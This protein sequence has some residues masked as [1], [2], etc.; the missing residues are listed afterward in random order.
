M[1]TISR[2]ARRGTAAA[3]VTCGAAAMAA[4]L[5][6]CGSGNGPSSASASQT[7][8]GKASS[9]GSG[10]PAGTA[11]GPASPAA[12]SAK[13]QCPATG[14]TATVD[15]SQGSAAA[16]S[17]YLPIDFTNISSH[18]C[19]MYGFPGVSWVTGIRG[20]QIGSA[21]TRES[22]YGPVT[23]TLAPGARAHAI[24]QIAVAGNF[25]ASACKPVTAHWLRIYPPD[26]YTA[27]YTKFSTQ[28]C[29]KKITGGSFPLGIMP[30][31]SGRGVNGQAP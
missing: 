10:T 14:L 15:S 25:P 17:S 22:S 19:I 5:T 27:L 1:N 7:P 28:V 13:T 9:A 23:V 21:A 30:V 18:T 11:H 20:S 31:R 29:S 4:L 2:V 6:A 24:V 26:Q 16:G 3:A 8:Q 12:G